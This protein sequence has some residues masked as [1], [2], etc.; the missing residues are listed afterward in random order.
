[1]LPAPTTI[2][3]STPWPRTSLTC[4]ATLATRAGSVPNSSEPISASPDSFNRIRLNAEAISAAAY[5]LAFT[6]NGQGLLAYR[7]PRKAADHDVLA[8]RGG[9]LVAQL[10]DGLAVELGVVH[11]LLE[12]HDRLI[13]RVELAGDDFVAD[14]VGLVGGFLLVDPRLGVAHVVGHVV[15]ADVLDARRRGD[16]QRDVARELHEIVVGRDEVG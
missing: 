4:R 5:P 16:L 7:E 13:P 8:G 10:L 11:L 14:V 6:A 2:A 1:M 9:Q 12:Q 3:T 15:A